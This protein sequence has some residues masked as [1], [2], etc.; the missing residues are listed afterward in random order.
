[1]HFTN[2]LGLPDAIV[3]AVTNDEYSRGNSD[4]S[5][6][7]LIGSPR[8][9]VLFRRH[10]EQIEVD[11]SERFWALWG[12]TIHTLLEDKAAGD[13]TVATEQ[14]LFTRIDGWNI[15]GQFDWLKWDG[16]ELSLKDYKLCTAYAAMSE[17][18]EWENQL[19]MLAW[20]IETVANEADEDG[21]LPD[22]PFC[23][24]DIG[25]VAL[26]RDWSRA[27]A[28]KDP[29]YPQSPILQLPQRLWPYEEREA[30][31]RER[32]RLHREARTHRMRGD[33]LAPCTDEERWIK[34]QDWAAM[35]P[36]AKRASRVFQTEEDAVE[37][38]KTKPELEVVRRKSEPTKCKLY[39]SVSSFCDQ[40]QRELLSSAEV[41]E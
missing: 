25:I 5:V 12:K 16:P 10:H 36:G 7:Q 15:S 38:A 37:Y 9:S 18:S 4:A 34:P 41:S 31:V 19:N 29:D 23:V 6:T 3:N 27:A 33:E 14:R 30:Y 35:K 26:I 40:Y 2:K 20:L 39:C 13:E 1:M 24:E 17:K 28:D 32:V 21:V 8:Q 22:E 11:V